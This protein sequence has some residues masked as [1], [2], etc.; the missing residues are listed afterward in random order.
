MTK[1]GV[2]SSKNKTH[3]NVCHPERVSSKVFGFLLRY[4]L[5]RFA[6]NLFN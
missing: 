6:A 4:N 5:Q 1:M 3:D 2:N